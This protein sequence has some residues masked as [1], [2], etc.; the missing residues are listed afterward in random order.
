MVE[1]CIE[2]FI[3]YLD[4]FYSF[5]FQNIFTIE[6]GF[7]LFLMLKDNFLQ[8]IVSDK[9]RDLSHTKTNIS[10]SSKENESTVRDN[11]FTKLFFE[12]FIFI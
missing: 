9:D 11:L 7:L 6:I 10:S 5:L 3:Q 8:K 2:I 4:T 1:E 12:F